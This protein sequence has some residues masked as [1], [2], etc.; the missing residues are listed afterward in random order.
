MKEQRPSKVVSIKNSALWAAYGD[1]LGFITEFVPDEATLLKRLGVGRL[2]DL[3]PWQRRIGGRYG[4]LV[5]LPVGCYSDDTQLRLATSR[6]IRGDGHFDVEVFSKIELPVWMNYA[7]GAGKGTKTAAGALCRVDTV[8]NT[9]FFDTGGSRYVDGGGNG[10]AMRI[11]PHVWACPDKRDNHTLLRDVLR[12]SMVTHGHPRGLIGAALHALTLRVALD[13]GNPPDLDRLVDLLDV[14]KDTPDII[15][16]D[17]EVREFWLPL[18]EQATSA[19]FSLS[20]RRCVGEIT[21]DLDILRRRLD[22]QPNVSY[23][24][25]VDH[26]GGLRPEVRGSGS[27][28]AIL[29]SFLA[30]RYRGRP[31]EA[32]V[33]S[34][35]CFGSDTDTIASM[36]G[37]LLGASCDLPPPSP[38]M[39]EE[40][41]ISE[42]ARTFAIR[43]GKTASNFP[44]PDLL[45]W[46][47]P[48]TQSDVVGIIGGELVLA[49]LGPVSPMGQA[50][51][52][53][54]Q[55]SYVYQWARL[56]FGQTVLMKR[57]ESPVQ[58][59]L[60]SVMVGFSPEKG[61]RI[62]ADEQED[63]F[64]GLSRRNDSE[65]E[66]RPSD[67]HR[68]LSVDEASQRA[69]DSGFDAA[70][71]GQLLLGFASSDEGIE[72]G[73]GYAAIVV[74]ARMAR[75]RKAK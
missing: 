31:H 24:E 62:S 72:R 14:V 6:T 37:A 30:W 13:S 49:G 46:S 64:D 33:E 22:A 71:V 11:H 16:S 10:A 32:V 27:K 12:N 3:V 21:E 19:D 53:D 57:R 73:I 28:A 15:R 2:I 74:K 75:L 25:I 55:G 8:W 34:A 56:K 39:D 29:A 23:R 59:G 54:K 48:R 67:K 7:L 60:Q 4:P 66:V 26:L 1:A 63:L 70:T 5:N 68:P 43:E 17:A 20:V 51:A 65:R 42:A 44:Y 58:L 61:R 47:P 9:N 69:I 50:Y 40:Y 38:I 52:A 41:I 35:N 36:A 18:W 45:K